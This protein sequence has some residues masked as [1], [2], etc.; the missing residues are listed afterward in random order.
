[1]ST[2]LWDAIKCFKHLQMLKKGQF[3]IYLQ[4]LLGINNSHGIHDWLLKN[5]TF[6]SSI[7]PLITFAPWS[8][9]LAHPTTQWTKKPI[10]K[11]PRPLLWNLQTNL[12]TFPFTIYSCKKHHLKPFRQNIRPNL[13]SRPWFKHIKM[14]NTLAWLIE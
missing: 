4:P 14:L 7:K 3:Y 2:W 1:M 9:F 8:Q 13:D 6:N 12:Q 10:K 5:W 11:W